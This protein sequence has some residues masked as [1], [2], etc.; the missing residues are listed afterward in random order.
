M[1]NKSKLISEL[2]EQHELLNK[3]I[4]EEMG[5]ISF[6]LLKALKELSDLTVLPLEWCDDEITFET[7]EKC[8]KCLKMC[9]M[10]LAI[11]SNNGFLKTL[12]L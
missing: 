6:D 5:S 10:L 2:V 9:E 1:A 3:T 11:N 4:M 12:L 8:N 7:Y